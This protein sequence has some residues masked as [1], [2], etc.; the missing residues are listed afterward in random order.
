MGLAFLDVNTYVTS[1]KVFKNLIIVGDFVKSLVFA[2]MQEAPYKFTSI[3]RDLQDRS[4][5]AGDF[6]VA[7]GQATFVSVDRHGDVRL[8]EF[9]PRDPESL[10]GEKLLLRTEFHTGSLVTCAKTIARRKTAEEEVA[11]QTQLVY[12]EYFGPEP[13]FIL[14]LFSLYYVF[15]T[16][17]S[18]RRRRNHNPRS[19]QGRTLSSSAARPRP[20]SPQCATYRGFE[21][22]V[23]PVSLCPSLSLIRR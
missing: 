3:S 14:S 11:P 22:K 8:L 4:V 7:E 5:V 20:T 1:L 16:N 23:V 19:S 12:G 9:N 2:A 6:L 10:N 18:H 13:S 17:H 21:P 15:L